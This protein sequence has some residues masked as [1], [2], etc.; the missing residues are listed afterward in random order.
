MQTSNAADQQTVSPLQAG[1]PDLRIVHADDL[2][3]LFGYARATSGFRRFCA[4]N[5]ITPVPGRGPYFDLKLV[6][7]RLDVVQGL[8]PAAPDAAKPSLVEQ[9]RRRLGSH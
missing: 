9:R 5:C 7:H 8:A 6:R 3:K 2:A 1:F 4:E